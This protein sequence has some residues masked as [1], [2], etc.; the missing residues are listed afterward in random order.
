MNVVPNPDEV[1]EEEDEYVEKIRYLGI[2][3]SKN[4]EHKQKS[5]WIKTINWYMLLR[6]L[7][8]YLQE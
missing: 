5:L 3:M 8:A 4:L 7:G 6:L 2:D 1:K